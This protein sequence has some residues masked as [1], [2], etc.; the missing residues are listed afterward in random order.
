MAAETAS[1]VMRSPWCASSE[2]RRARSMRSQHSPSGSGTLT[3]WGVKPAVARTLL[4]RRLD[5]TI[6][7]EMDFVQR[8]DIRAIGFWEQDYPPLL[9]ECPDAP[10]MLLAKGAFDFR[11]LPFALAIVGTRAMTARISLL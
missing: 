11:E 5:D 10:V 3:G 6:R 8:N 4:E 2:P 1:S 7:R 9:R